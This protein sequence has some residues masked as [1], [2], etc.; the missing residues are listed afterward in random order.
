MED[1]RAYSVTV[2]VGE[3][4]KV[5]SYEP[6]D[7][8]DNGQSAAII[9]ANGFA[10]H[11]ETELTADEVRE[12]LLQTVFLSELEL[13]EETCEA[14]EESAPVEA[15]AA[16][17]EEPEKGAEPSPET[18]RESRRHHPPPAASVDHLGQRQQARPHDGP[19]G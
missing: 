2:E 9:R 13:T 18:G 3:Y 1:V 16:T 6:A 5:L 11:F 8:M 14:S 10:I 19:D 7:I 4:A 12:K 17:A 15:A